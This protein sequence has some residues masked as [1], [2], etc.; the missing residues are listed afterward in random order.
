[1]SDYWQYGGL[2]TI[3]RQLA[4]KGQLRAFDGWWAAVRIDR[5]LREGRENRMTRAE[6]EKLL[7]LGG[8]KDPATGAWTGPAEFP[9]FQRVHDQIPEL[10]ERML[11]VPLEAGLI[12]KGLFDLFTKD[13]DYAPLYRIITASEDKNVVLGPFGSKRSVEGQRNPAKELKGG[14]SQINDPIENLITNWTAFTALSYKNLAMQKV[15][16]AMV[17]AGV[18]EKSK[19]RWF[20]KAQVTPEQAARALEDIG[21]QVEGMTPEQHRQILVL[22]D[23]QADQDNARAAL[24]RRRCHLPIA[25]GI[26]DNGTLRQ[27]GSEFCET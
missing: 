16:D 11:R 10:N 5:L 12:S 22:A 13:R 2:D 26:F 25:K 3:M 19:W 17:E 27:M 6:V 20:D 21:V 9:L 1:M 14:T 18:M 23:E 4:D 7:R 15:R 24:P 8:R